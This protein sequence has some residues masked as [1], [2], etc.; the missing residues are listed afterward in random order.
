MAIQ[1]QQEGVA[2]VYQ[3]KCRYQRGSGDAYL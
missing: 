1:Q 3:Y 2:I